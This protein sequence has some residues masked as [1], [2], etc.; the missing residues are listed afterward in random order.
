MFFCTIF[1]L[2]ELMTLGFISL[3]LTFGQNYISR[4]C[5]PEKF[6]DM[7]LPCRIKPE[8]AAAEAH[9]PRKPDDSAEGGHHRRLVSQVAMDLTSKRRF[10]SA[11]LLPLSC[12]PV[13]G[14]I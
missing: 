2:A 13:S 6:A 3:L 10:L 14:S 7:M 8:T 9:N 1:C 4:I 5:I 11:G 12:S